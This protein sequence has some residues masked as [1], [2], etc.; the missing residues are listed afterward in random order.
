MP[1]DVAR[2]RRRA[3]P[4]KFLIVPPVIGFVVGGVNQ[5]RNDLQVSLDNQDGAGVLVAFAV[6]G[7][8]K[9]RN[10]GTASKSF[11]SVHYAFVCSD[12]HAEVVVLQKFVHSIRPILHNVTSL[13]WIANIVRLDAK[14]SIRLGW[15]GPEDVQDKFVLAS[16]YLLNHFYRPLDLSDVVN[17]AYIAANAAVNAKNFIFN[18]SSQG[19]PLEQ[20]VDALEDG[21]RIL[22]VLLAL[23][24][25]FVHEAEVGVDGD[26]L[27]VASDHVNL[28]GIGCFERQ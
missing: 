2:W 20:S 10:E 9:Y 18:N 11:E 5:L 22:R 7:R 1:V 6:V 13:I 3:S 24:L 19:Q 21:I 16:G 28:I 25:T 15:V 14:F 27:V 8:R 23:F 12:D 17:I 4:H 26:I